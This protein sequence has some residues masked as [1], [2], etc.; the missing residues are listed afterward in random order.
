MGLTT[1]RYDCPGQVM[2]S[3]ETDRPQPAAQRAV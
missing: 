1:A 3:W 2:R